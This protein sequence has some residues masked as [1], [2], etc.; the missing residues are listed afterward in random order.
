MLETFRHFYRLIWDWLTDWFGLL[1]NTY[2]ALIT[3]LLVMLLYLFFIYLS[4]VYLPGFPKK[5][6]VYFKGFLLEH[7]VLSIYCQSIVYVN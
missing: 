6:S 2:I 7:P 4:I 5:M 3:W 1:M